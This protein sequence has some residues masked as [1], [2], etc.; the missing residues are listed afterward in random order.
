VPLKILDR[1]LVREIVPPLLLA[2]VGLTFVLMMPPI[3]QNAEQLIA[4]GVGW[5]IIFRA[6]L[7]L[8]PQALSVTIPMALLYGVLFGLGRLSA[9]REF[10]ALQ[11]CAVS[12]YRLMRPIALLAVLASAAT[13]YETIVALPDANQTYRELT[14]N[15]V[16]S[17]AESDV[18]PRVF[19]TTFPNR[20]LY[21]RDIP[22]GS[23]WK[24]VF[25]ADATQPDR[26]TVYLARQGRLAIDR[27]KRKVELVL[28]NGTN[29]TTYPSRPDAYDGSSFDRIVLDM[30]ADAVFPRAQIIK[31]DNEKSIAEL[32]QTAADNVAHGATNFSQLYTIQQKFSLPAA[33]LV[34]ALIGLALGVSNRKDGR[35]A[36]FAL[37]TGVVFA[38]YVLLY[39]SR[40]AAL[41]GRLPPGPAPWL[42]NL[43]LGVAGIALLVWRAGSA[44]QPI[45][46][47]IPTFW[48]RLE[49][50]PQPAAT[51]GAPSSRRRRV[52]VV[53]RI[54][55]INWPRPTL[56]DIYVSR[57]YLSV[58]AMA[59]VALVGIFYISTF[60]DLADKL[61]GG[62]A[63]ARLLLSYFYFATPQYVYYIIPMAALVATLVTIGLLTKNSE[64]IVMK[65]CGIS[66][67]RAALPL[68]LFAVVFS[69]VLF[70]MQEQVL[71]VSNREATRLNAI[72]RGYPMEHFGV[73]NRQWIVG[74]SGD[75]YRYELFDPRVNQFSRLSI[76]HLDES[77]WK[78]DTLT[79]AREAA[80]VKHAGADDQPVLMWMARAG[81]RRE[82]ATAKRRDAVHPVV[83][84]T[85]FTERTVSLEPPSY[86]KTDEVEA[87]RMTYR[88]LKDYIAQL[89]SSGYHVVPYMVQLQR[90]IAFP[91][92]TLVMTL[93][94]VPFAVTTGRSGAF[95][96]IGVGLVLALIYWTALSIFGALGAGGWMS[97]MLAAWAPNILFGAAA[98]YLLLTVRT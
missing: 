56:L 22:P 51:Y 62:R 42:V 89:K 41:A 17:G 76:F 28:E 7:T 39:S 52:V 14:F 2:L 84:Y 86:F 47:S 8:T 54:P 21:V 29:H 32:R 87:D 63:S 66:L 27:V 53:V 36:S 64:L 95:Y 92:V 26:T 10:V 33:C 46:I 38:Y 45:R 75:I 61:F 31:G 4:K 78:L 96:G 91:F 93:L 70:E 57:Q 85:P 40:A 11:A 50:D 72:I 80:L 58:F 9:D 3:L 43:V 90:K 6:L 94:A 68:L 35:L 77:A 60:I 48:R 49:K 5:S 73:L 25:L 55:H 13:A 82:F 1:Y 12:I 19:F 97:P 65:A 15:A 81:W 23:S 98:A 24:D 16:A 74:K 71:A 30:D 83:K 79:Y 18:K 88:E 67:Y 69:I 59:F 34:L 37:G 20:V 44:G